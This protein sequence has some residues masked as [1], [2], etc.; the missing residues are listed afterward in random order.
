MF[1]ELTVLNVIS[2]LILGK[3]ELVKSLVL[4]SISDSFTGF[5]CYAQLVVK[6][7]DSCPGVTFLR[8][9]SDIID[10]CK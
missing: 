9:K 3:D 4:K 1:H 10:I 2:Y 5:S 8:K 6:S 7:S